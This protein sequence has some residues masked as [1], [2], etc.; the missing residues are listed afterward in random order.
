MKEISLANNKGV[1][2]VDDEDFEYLNQY[3][4]YIRPNRNTFYAETKIKQIPIRIHRLILKEYDKKVFIDHKDRNGLNNQKDNLRK[5][6]RTENN[7]N[8]AKSK[9]SKWKYKGVKNVSTYPSAKKH[10]CHNLKRPWQATIYNN[11]K[12]IFLGFFRTEDEAAIAYNNASLELFGEF[13][14]LNVI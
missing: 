8:R 4:W 2:L 6:T 1:I 7:R 10:R 11:R 9:H 12:R 5:A 3:S 13:A 14:C